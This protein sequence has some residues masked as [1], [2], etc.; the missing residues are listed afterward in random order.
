MYLF[1]VYHVTVCLFS[2]ADKPP[3][4]QRPSSGKFHNRGSG[5][6]FPSTCQNNVFTNEKQENLSSRTKVKSDESLKSQD[7]DDSLALVLHPDFNPTDEDTLTSTPKEP[8]RYCRRTQSAKARSRPRVESA[9]TLSRRPQ[10]ASLNGKRPTICR[11]E[12]LEK[13]VAVINLANKVIPDLFEI[14]KEKILALPDPRSHH[15][16]IQDFT[17]MHFS[18]PF[19]ATS[20]SKESEVSSCKKESLQESDLKPSIYGLNRQRHY[21]GSSPDLSSANCDFNLYPYKL[22]DDVDGG[23]LIDETKSKRCGLTYIFRKMMFQF[24]M[25]L[26]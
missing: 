12:Q 25:C 4:P 23:N 15:N 22:T 19:S 26:I 14:E 5:K 16:A 7:T 8:P 13:S 11:D 9:K 17:P 10:S 24:N 3:L 20:Y 21:Y 1:T 6:L 2:V 18:R